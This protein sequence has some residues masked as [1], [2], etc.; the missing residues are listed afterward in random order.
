[1]TREEQNKILD[2]KIESNVNQYK[3]DRLNAETSAFSSG[4][5]NKYEFFKRIDL[6]YKPNALDKARFE[7]SPLGRAFNEG[8][9]KTIP[10][11]QEEGVIQL[12]K[13]IRDNLA[14]GINIPAGLVIPPGPQDPPGPPGPQGPPPPS[15]SPT[16]ITTP[17]T[18]PPTTPSLSPP[19]P[20][21]ILPTP[22]SI[23]PIPP[24]LSSSLTNVTPLGPRRSRIPRSSG[25]Q[26]DLDL[27][28]LFRSRKRYDLNKLKSDLD[29]SDILN[30]L[31]SPPDFHANK[32]LDELRS[33]EPV[34]TSS[35]SAQDEESFPMP[36]IKHVSNKMLSE[37]PFQTPL[38][39]MP[40]P[41]IR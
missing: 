16:N 15:P 38:S 32:F 41:T 9:D 30:Q 20:P 29:Y 39:S 28:D 6:N 24:S 11:Y 35:I 1:M 17:S 8:L 4:N 5:L 2:D 36:K 31:R 7:F 18:S 12:L 3:V 22:P 23:P 10:N 33:Q 37:R 19:T 13:G 27:K 40:T 26:S 21:S 25:S 14:G 34:S